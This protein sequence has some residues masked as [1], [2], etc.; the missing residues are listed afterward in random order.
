[1]FLCMAYFD[2]IKAPLTL[3]SA[4]VRASQCKCARVRI[5]A[6]GRHVARPVLAAVRSRRRYGA[7]LSASHMPREMS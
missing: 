1:M 4:P 6:C 3:R 7:F 5:D 2:T